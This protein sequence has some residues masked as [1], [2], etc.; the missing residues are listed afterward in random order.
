[1]ST[2]LNRLEWR[3]AT[4]AFDPTKPVSPENLQ[5]I[6]AAI[7]MAPTSFGLQPFHV[8]VVSDEET[9]QKIF[10]VGWKQ[11]QYSTAS[12]ILVFSSLT[13]VSERITE[14]LDIMSGGDATRRAQL[15]GY[16]GMMRGALEKRS[17][18]EL[19]AWADRQ[20][21]IALG[22]AM[23]ACAE[24]GVDSCPMEGFSPPDLD[25]IMQYPSH[26]FSCVMLTLGYRDP[27]V[28]VR[29]KVRFPQKD[30]FS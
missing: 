19:Q 24:L 14:Y 12:H 25:K 21:Y 28:P 4:K 26:Q 30:L 15:K 1:M 27:K 18:T 10:A 8:D 7:R 6:L 16:E 2:F 17:P 22:F 5:K 29:E 20:A 11:P 3:H 13:H 9:K 23:A